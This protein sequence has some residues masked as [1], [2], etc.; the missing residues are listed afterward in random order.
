MS[1]W[2]RIYYNTLFGALG[3]LLGW[4]LFGEWID[5]R[6]NWWMLALAGG[7]LIGAMIGYCIASV[8][9]FHDAVLLRFIRFA[10]MGTLLGAMGGALGFWLGESIHYW[11]LPSSG[12]LNWINTATLIISR[13]LGWGFFGLAVGM[14]E[15]LALRSVRLC[16]FGAL[17]GMLG[18]ALG[19]AVFGLLMVLW[20]PSEHSYIWGQALGLIILG[21]CIGL[22][23]A[24]VEQ[25]L[26]PACLQ[27]VRGWREGREFRVIKQQNSLGRDEGADILLL[28][29]MNIAKKHAVIS[30]KGHGYVLILQEGRPEQTLINSTP[31]YSGQSL[32]DGDRLQIGATVLRFKQRKSM[33]SQKQ[34]ASNGQ[35]TNPQPEG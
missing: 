34:S 25:A 23:S 10:S 2:H 32:K 13:A 14:S 27:V 16:R 3:G 11:L 22:L 12:E 19:G 26:Q 8:E 29:D 17:G 6:W 30:Q 15:G 35:L 21:A 4:M 33:P 7:A 5:A 31:A 1:R 24:L 18:G 28:R 9:A 20:D